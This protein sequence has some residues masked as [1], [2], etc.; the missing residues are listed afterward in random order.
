VTNSVAASPHRTLT[1]KMTK[2]WSAKN[3]LVPPSVN[4]AMTLTQATSVAAEK[5]PTRCAETYAPRTRKK[6]RAL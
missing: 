2:T 6:S 1:L 4:S 3:G 5:K